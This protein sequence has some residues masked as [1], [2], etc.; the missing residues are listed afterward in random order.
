[1][2]FPFRWVREAECHTVH[3]Q[4]FELVMDPEQV[5]PAISVQEEWN[6]SRGII[7]GVKDADGTLLEDHICEELRGGTPVDAGERIVGAKN[8]RRQVWAADYH[9]QQFAKRY[10][11]R[12]IVAW[13][14]NGNLLSN[15]HFVGYAEGKL[16]R[17]RSEC[18]AMQNRP[19][20]S[21]VVRK[22]GE[23]KRVS[24]DT[25]RYE[26]P[27]AAVTIRNGAG[28][29]ITA[30][31]ECATF[32]QHL[33][34]DG[35]AIGD[36]ELKAMALAGQFY[37]LRH[38]FLF[39]RIRMGTRDE[40][41]WL[42]AGLAA[43]WDGHGGLDTDCLERAMDGQSIDVDVSSLDSAAIHLAM[44]EKGYDQAVE[45]RQPGQYTVK[46]GRMRVVL[47]EGIYPHNLIGIRRDDSVISVVLR[48]QSNR[49]GVTICGAAKIM[50]DLGAWN[51]LLLDN[52]GDVVMA[53]GDEHILEPAQRGRTEWRSVLFFA[54]M[55]DL[56][57]VP[58]EALRLVRHPEQQYAESAGS[59][60]AR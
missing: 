31:V 38:L 48:G 45:P 56:R 8:M 10:P 46:G 35:E 54:A 21:L 36:A 40:Q 59:E 6:L 4:V 13:V 34:R 23:G 3:G 52:G 11:D 57:D 53:L 14:G 50:R 26:C 44:D 58:P 33:V 1:M 32:G 41:R 9:K 42:D 2:S 20:T 19:Y 27:P 24:I 18:G 30:Q 55:K 12:K 43:F 17:L 60:A 25:L 5:V 22:P 16:Y 15:P 29:D 47:L 39:G 49:V 51:A 37:D 28:A 7:R